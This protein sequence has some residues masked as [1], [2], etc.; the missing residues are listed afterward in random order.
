M[1]GRTLF[2]GFAVFLAIFAFGLF[3]TI[4]YA[5]YTETE[6]T[7]YRLTDELEVMNYV[8]IDAQTSPIKYRACFKLPAGAE[9]YGN[10][11][12]ATPL[13]AP[14]WFECFNAQQLTKDLEA[15]EV[16]A[17]RY[18]DNKPYGVSSYMIVYPDGR[19]Y[20]WRQLNE[21][22]QAKFSGETPPETCPKSENNNG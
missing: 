16:F 18:E 6:H 17:I 2:T 7:R 13:V 1:K 19:G 3:Y 12:G 9:L 11:E 10:A 15:G 14:Y 22:G 5:Y 21:C 8:E 20:A 4:N